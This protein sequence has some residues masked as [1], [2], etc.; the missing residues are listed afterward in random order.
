MLSSLMLSEIRFPQTNNI[1]TDKQEE[2]GQPDVSQQIKSQVVFRVGIFTCI[3]T[4]K[5]NV[6]STVI[7]SDY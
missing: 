7:L 1:F 6:L 2:D 4:V 3:N 5:G